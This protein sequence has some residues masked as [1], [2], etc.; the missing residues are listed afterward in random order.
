MTT[1]EIRPT[2]TGIYGIP[3]AARYLA[4]TPP[5]TNGYKVPTPRLRYWIRTSVMPTSPHIY[6][7]RERFISFLD[8]I[9]MRMIAVLRYKKVQL[10]EI[11]NTE[12][13]LRKEFGIP[14]PLASKGLW[15]YGSNVFI[16]FHE[17]IITASRFGQEAMSFID[18]WLIKVELDM[19][20]DSEELVNSWAVHRNIRID[21]KIQFGEPCIIGTRIPTSAVWSNVKA[22]DSPETIALAYSVDISKIQSAIDW[23]RRLDRITTKDDTFLHS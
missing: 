18:N 8:L 21:P 2:Y 3:E 20:F 10:R 4:V 23:E 17:H 14:Y 5:L 22:G 6:P 11:R 7:T 9:S 12:K 16:K 1:V 15:T 13:W 19:T